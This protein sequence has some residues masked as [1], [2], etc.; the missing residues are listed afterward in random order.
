[1]PAHYAHYR[2]GRQVLSA[3][4]PEVR[5]EIQR[6]RRM[7]DMGLHGPDIF[8]YYY[9]FLTTAVGDLGKSF[10]RQPGQDF[11][12]R[13][14]AAA[15]SEAARAYLYGLL[16][17]YCLDSACHPFVH[18]MVDSGEAG[19]VALESEFDRYL[20][21]M[22][23]ITAPHS[24]DVT[25]HMKLTRGECM[26]V[27][28]FYPP[29]TG[30]NVSQSVQFMGFAVRFLAGGNR[31]KREALLKKLKPGITDHMIPPEPVA[32]FARMDSE[33]LARFNRAVK[34]Y[35]EL[36][37]QLLAHKRTGE[38]LGGDFAPNFG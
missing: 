3:M 9:P 37:A 22:D 38:P 15:N 20:M 16:A 27:A 17:H 4:P 24:H 10:H 21:A 25:R 18:K 5:Q 6:F 33:L 26:T 30:A 7:Y 32:A 12:P 2:F 1:M 14:C 13:A 8:F 29:A 23:G 31:E 35:P 11:F 19:H 28:E 34:Q 36:L